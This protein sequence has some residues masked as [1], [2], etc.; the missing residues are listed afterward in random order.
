MARVVI[1]S[2]ADADTAGILLDLAAKAGHRVAQKYDGLFE[3]L[4]DRLEDHP[5]SG[6]PRPAIAPD[7]R[8]GIVSP[9]TV[10]YRHS[11]EDDTVT[12]LRIVHGRR[13]MS[14]A[15]LGETPS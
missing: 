8:I 15:L 4:Y 10:I 1:A 11:L 14:G 12:V 2:T 5:A 13:R 7:I 9:Y 3:R 6:A